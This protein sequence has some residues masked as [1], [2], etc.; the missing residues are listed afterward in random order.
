MTPILIKFFLL[1]FQNNEEICLKKILSK[2]PKEANISC[3]SS[4]YR[5]LRI[6]LY[7]FATSSP[8]QRPLAPLPTS[9]RFPYVGFLTP[10]FNAPTMHLFQL[11]ESTKCHCFKNSKASV[12]KK[13]M[14]VFN[15][16]NCLSWYIP[17]PVCHLSL[18]YGKRK[19]LALW[20][21]SG[22]TTCNTGIPY[23]NSLIPSSLLTCPGKQEQM[24]QV[25]GFLAF[26]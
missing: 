11:L 8:S 20:H 21:S 26:I 23:L 16:L 7:I 19:G 1:Y 24:T 9:Y 18:K 2:L 5:S 17:N 22:D 4:T 10:V 15:F 6:Q 3:K 14:N 13:S 25:L 12:Y